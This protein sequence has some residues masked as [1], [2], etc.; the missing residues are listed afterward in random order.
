MNDQKFIEL[1]HKVIIVKKNRKQSVIMWSLHHSIFDGESGRVLQRTFMQYLNNYKVNSINERIQIKDYHHFITEITRQELG[2]QAQ[3]LIRTLELEKYKALQNK[4]QAAILGNLEE[5]E[6]DLLNVSLKIP[7]EYEKSFNENV[8]NISFELFC[9][10][11]AAYLKVDSAPALIY[12]NGRRQGDTYYS[13]IGEYID[14]TPVVI[15]TSSS[16][17]Q[18]S[19]IDEKMKYL[20]KNKINFSNLALSSDSNNFVKEYFVNENGV[21]NYQLMFN[22][23]GYKSLHDQ[24]LLSYMYKANISRSENSGD[25]SHMLNGLTFNVMYSENNIVVMINNVN[26]KSEDE[27]KRVFTET[28]LTCLEQFNTNIVK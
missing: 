12:S 14:L 9:V 18:W 8:W 24:D 16:S 7:E 15:D 1:L 25:T 2:V 28:L 5:D 3:D 22:F 20:S 4:I 6:G 23:L 10:F 13:S 19:L 17:K 21:F 26:K 11:C 27:L